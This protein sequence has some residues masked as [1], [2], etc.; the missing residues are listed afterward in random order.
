MIAAA[1]QGQKQKLKIVRDAEFMNG[2]HYTVLRKIGHSKKSVIIE[3]NEPTLFHLW[4]NS[5]EIA[6]CS[7]IRMVAIDIY[8]V[9]ISIRH[10]RDNSN[11]V[12]F[13]NADLV[14]GNFAF[15]PFAR[16]FRPLWLNIDEV[17]LRWTRPS[18]YALRVVALKN[19]DFCTYCVLRHAL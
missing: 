1:L 2:F 5:V 7:G 19:P 12:S 10:G 18:H 11:G 13:V 6:F 8:P 16:N 15:E 9:K 14:G 17:K 3:R 4:Q